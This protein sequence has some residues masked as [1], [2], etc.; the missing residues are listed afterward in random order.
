MIE[1][2]ERDVDPR[3]QRVQPHPGGV[4]GLHLAQLV[5][6]VLGHQEE[7]VE[8]A[9]DQPFIGTGSDRVCCTVVAC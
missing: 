7:V 2:R 5:G 4:V 3:A 9:A 1:H 8:E 6:V